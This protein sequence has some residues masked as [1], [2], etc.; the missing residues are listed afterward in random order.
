MPSKPMLSVGN[1][2]TPFSPS[3]T[4]HSS[5]S[6]GPSEV[7]TYQIRFTSSH[8]IASR[9]RFGCSQAT[10]SSVINSRYWQATQGFGNQGSKTAIKKQSPK[11]PARYQPNDTPDA[12]IHT[13]SAVN[14]VDT[15][16]VNHLIGS[17]TVA[18]LLSE[19]V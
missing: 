17:E 15:I 2:Q 11:N 9:G 18:F 8:R 5:G 12:I 3:R 10:S 14:R 7:V 16:N 1:E 4:S 19:I 13:P 6:R